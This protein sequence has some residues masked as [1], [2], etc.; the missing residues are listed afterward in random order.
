[1]TFEKLGYDSPIKN[2]KRIEWR[3][4]HYEQQWGPEVVTYY[5]DTHGWDKAITD[6]YGYSNLHPLKNEEIIAIYE[7]LMKE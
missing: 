6:H 1:M 7:Y 5:T 4:D 3:K 2:G